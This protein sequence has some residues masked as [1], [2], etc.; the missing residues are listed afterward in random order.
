MKEGSLVLNSKDYASFQQWVQ[1]DLESVSWQGRY[2]KEF[3]EFWNRIFLDD[4]P[5]RETLELLAF[6]K[7]KAPKGPLG[8]WIGWLSERLICY[9]FVH[10]PI[11][12][13]E[14]SFQSGLSFSETSTLLR[15]FF[16]ELFPQYEEY[17]NNA[18]Q[19][20]HVIH[21]NSYLCFNDV[22]EHLHMSTPITGVRENEVMA[23]MEVT[24][25]PEWH[26][27]NHWLE[28]LSLRENE[29]PK[30]KLWG[31]RKEY[32][33]ATREVIL[34]LILALLSLYAI[35]SFNIWY[36]KYLAE[37][38]KIFEPQFL[39]TDKTLAFKPQSQKIASAL[40]LPR[41][42]EL[43]NIDISLNSDSERAITEKDPF[44]TESEVE[45]AEVENL[46]R[47]LGSVSG[48]SDFDESKMGLREDGRG[49]KKAY[50]L[51]IKAADLVHART[52]IDQVMNKY[53]AI[54]ADKVQPGTYVPGGLYYNLFVPQ[55]FLREF[56]AQ[57]GQGLE[58]TLYE[59]RTRLENP[60]GKSKVFV[61]VKAF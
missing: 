58:A 2:E 11:S 51:M 42:V 49:N 26:E 32:W 20:T 1:L 6:I 56:L 37:K 15:N 35:K 17:F 44:V 55:A 43:E 53:Q 28:H 50:R 27:L 41:F 54:K 61:W 12:I 5:F 23:S 31:S 22:V 9:I 29:E 34:L 57:V 8:A 13:R 25:Y 16:S 59:S 38:I 40:N 47:D 39:W 52:Y 45:L 19:V 36:E 48:R 46:P 30:K 24:L 33:K 3:E 10:Y 14:L 18:F 7:V 4:R 21:E 60:P